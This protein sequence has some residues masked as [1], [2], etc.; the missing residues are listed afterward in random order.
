MLAIAFGDSTVSLISAQTGKIV[1]QISY[2]GQTTTGICCMGWAFNF[3]D[4]KNT[5]ARLD[6]LPINTKLDDI[7]SRGGQLH[8]ADG[9]LDLPTDL[10][11]LDVIS[12]LP[13]LSVL[14]A[15]NREWVL[16]ILTFLPV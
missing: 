16:L 12:S 9:P 15:R 2:Q 4:V 13:K 11:F 3:T 10:A 7:F 8:D 6:R 5:K 14:P 1:Q